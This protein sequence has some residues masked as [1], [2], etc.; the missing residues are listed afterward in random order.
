MIMDYVDSELNLIPIDEEAK[1]KI[2]FVL[3]VFAQQ[4]HSGFSSSMMIGSFQKYVNTPIK[5]IEDKLFYSLEFKEN[6]ER[7]M[8]LMF[9]TH[10]K[11]LIAAF[12][13]LKGKYFGFYMDIVVKLMK[14]D[15]ITPITFE[16]DQWNDV[17]EY[18]YSADTG[19]RYFQHKRATDV[20]KDFN[21]TIFHSGHY[22][23]SE[24]TDGGDSWFTCRHSS[25]D[26]N[27]TTYTPF[28]VYLNLPFIEKVYKYLMEDSCN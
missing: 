15:P 25:M 19:K 22:V 27:T 24:R 18:Y 28:K 2:K 4:G 14:L 6:D 3:N 10:L 21:G 9:V 12:E 16:D 20:F 5:E 8:Q 1:N 13:P 23:F 17:S 26:I 7:D 11:Q